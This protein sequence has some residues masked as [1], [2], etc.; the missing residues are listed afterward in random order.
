MPLKFGRSTKSSLALTALM[1]V[2]FAVH[3]AHVSAKRSVAFQMLLAVR[4]F[5]E[6]TRAAYSARVQV[7][8]L[9]KYEGLLWLLL[10]FAL[11]DPNGIWKCTQKCR[12]DGEVL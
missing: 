3:D 12:Y 1:V 9:N 11:G 2:A 6:M 7:D 5:V 4:T 8:W 10:G